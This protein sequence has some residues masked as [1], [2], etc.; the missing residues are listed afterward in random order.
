M[1]DMA[2]VLSYI[3]QQVPMPSASTSSLSVQEVPTVADSQ[4]KLKH[5]SGP[6]AVASESPSAPR[7]VLDKVGNTSEHTLMAP[8]LDQVML[9]IF[10]CKKC[11]SQ[12]NFNDFAVMTLQ[13]YS[14]PV[15]W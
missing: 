11:Q 12:H 10:D 3:R 13:V 2:A 1:E 5:T 9:C 8:I 14:R 6:A 15:K 4:Q 7:A